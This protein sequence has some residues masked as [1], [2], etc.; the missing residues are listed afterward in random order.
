MQKYD[1]KVNEVFIGN[2]AMYLVITGDF[3]AKIK[4]SEGN[5]IED[6]VGLCGLGTRQ[7]R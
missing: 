2:K 5:W 7:N 6:A 3:N 1:N 4:K